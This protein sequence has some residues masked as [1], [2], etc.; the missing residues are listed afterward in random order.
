MATLE[1][2]DLSPWAHVAPVVDFV[3]DE[4]W[5][6]WRRPATLAPADDDETHVW[7]EGDRLGVLAYRAWGDARLWW[8][9]CDVND[10]VDPFAIEPG[11]VL[12]V[13]SLAR[14]QLEV[15]P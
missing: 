14:V 13:P 5:F 2:S 4:V 10:V 6:P 1:V 7:V 9:L 12:R 11:A 8:V 3:R 15:L